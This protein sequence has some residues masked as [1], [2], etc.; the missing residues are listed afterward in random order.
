[1]SSLDEFEMPKARFFEKKKQEAKAKVSKVFDEYKEIL[2]D[3]THP[4]NQK[5]SYQIKVK[6]TLQRLLTSADELEESAPG[7]GI[8]G[9]VIL[10]LRSILFLKDKNIELEKEIFELRK[11]ISR[12]K[13]EDR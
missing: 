9:L 11:E 12:M 1:M 5:N 4:K 8:Y 7:E 10:S 13:K 2:R 6:K 3:K